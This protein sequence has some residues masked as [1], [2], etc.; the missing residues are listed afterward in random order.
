[1]S[2]TGISPLIY[3]GIIIYIIPVLLGILKINVPGWIMH[4]GLAV[5]VVGIMHTIYL[6]R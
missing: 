5:L 1:M 3:L 2:G 4:I 6:R